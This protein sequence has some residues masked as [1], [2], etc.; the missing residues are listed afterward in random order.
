MME[1]EQEKLVKVKVEEEEVGVEECVHLSHRVNPP[2]RKFL[3]PA[4]VQDVSVLRQS[5]PPWP[6]TRVAR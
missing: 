1:E 2:V 6:A 3:T 5:A 4:G